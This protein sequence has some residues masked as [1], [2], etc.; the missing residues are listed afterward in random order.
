MKFLYETHL[1]TCQGS[2]CGRSPGREYPQLFKDLGYDGI[3]VTDHFF[4]GNCAA[5]R[6]GE[7]VNRVD[8]YMAGYRDAKEAGER[9]GF[10]VFFGIEQNYH[11]DEYLLYGIDR[12]FLLMNPDIESW[13]RQ[14]LFDNV[15]AYGGCVVQAHPFRERGY[16]TKMHF[17]LDGIDAAEAVNIGNHPWEDASAL[18]YISYLGLPR[19]CGSDIHSALNAVPEKLAAVALDEKLTTSKDYAAYIRAKKPISLLFPPERLICERPGMP[20]TPY[21]I[22][23]GDSLTEAFDLSLSIGLEQA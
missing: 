23:T 10:D 7:W 16:I 15:H 14:T 19:T 12:E 17:Q 3:F 20:Y 18:K 9:I 11:G 8:A 2:A 22:G 5:P 1:H 13:S 21:E 4:Q 6:S